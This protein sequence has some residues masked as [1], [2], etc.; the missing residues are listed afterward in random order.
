MW[1]SL[2]AVSAAV[3]ACSAARVIDLVTLGSNSGAAALGCCG[4]GSC[5]AGA[6]CCGCSVRMATGGAS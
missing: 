3:V 5:I 2:F 1:L 6:C 4:V